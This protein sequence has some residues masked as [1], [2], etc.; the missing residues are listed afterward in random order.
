MFGRARIAARVLALILRRTRESGLQSGWTCARAFFLNGM[1]RLRNRFGPKDAVACPC[2]GWQGAQFRVIDCGKFIVP[3]AECPQCYGHERHRMLHLYFM[4]HAPGFLQPGASGWLLY[5]APEHHLKPFLEKA[6]HLRVLNTDV[7]AGRT[8]LGE[9]PR[10]VSD[11]ETL[12]LASESVEG[13]ICLHVLEHV[14]ND[15]NGIRELHRVLAPG[16][17]AIIMVPFMMDQ[18]ETEEYGRPI[19][20]WFDHVRGY[21]PLDFKHRLAPLS[22]DEVYPADFLSPEEIQ[23]YKVPDSQVIYRC[24][25]AAVQESSKLAQAQ[26]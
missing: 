21:S 2:C 18:T 19:P 26:A 15:A 16:G 8:L 3:D 9:G 13:I 25:R 23:R 7:D 17:E 14:P 24:R 12:P 11:M 1:V 6:P 22:Y 10:M 20:D 5:F 4:R